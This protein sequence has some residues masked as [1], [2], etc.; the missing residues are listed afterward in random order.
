M[1]YLATL[2]KM[3]QASSDYLIYNI[4]CEREMHVNAEAV[5]FLRILEI[6]NLIFKPSS[7]SG[8]KRIQIYDTCQI[9]VVI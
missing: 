6:I 9:N 5:K 2:S 4:F 3:P 1:A 7:I 8:N